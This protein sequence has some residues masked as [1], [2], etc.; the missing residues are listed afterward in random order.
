MKYIA[1]NEA[2]AI[3]LDV[4]PENHP[5]KK[6]NGIVVFKEDLKTVWEHKN[7]QTL[8]DVEVLTVQEALQKT[9]TWK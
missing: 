6:S 1:M 4:I 7:N 3:E 8:E 9:E 2:L 5:Y